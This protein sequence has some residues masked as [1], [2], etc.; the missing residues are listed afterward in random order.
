MKKISDCKE[1]FLALVRAGMW[2]VVNENDNETN[3]FSRVWI[4]V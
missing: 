1:A 2:G 4:G 3:T